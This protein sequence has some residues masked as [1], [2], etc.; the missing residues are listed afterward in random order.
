MDAA[1]YAKRTA[2]TQVD[3]KRRGEQAAKQDDG[4]DSNSIELVVVL[5]SAGREGRQEWDCRGVSLLLNFLFV[6][7]S[8]AL[9]QPRLCI[10]QL[11]PRQQ[12]W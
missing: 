3:F 1:Q 10:S 4:T 2:E 9:Q 6:S 5:D 12:R 11:E 8:R 7:G